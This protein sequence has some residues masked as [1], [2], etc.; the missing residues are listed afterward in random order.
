MYD[1][2]KKCNL[3]LIIIINFYFILFIVVWFYRFQTVIFLLTSP[4]YLSNLGVDLELYVDK[5]SLGELKKLARHLF[6]KQNII[7]DNFILTTRRNEME[8]FSVY[9]FKEM[10]GHLEIPSKI[11]YMVWSE[12]WKNQWLYHKFLQEYCKLGHL[13]KLIVKKLN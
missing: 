5:N 13:N 1:A 2:I 12:S 4:F 7:E 10:L 9:Q 8:K 11:G 3:Q 6:L